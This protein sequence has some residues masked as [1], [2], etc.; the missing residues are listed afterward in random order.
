MRKPAILRRPL[1]QKIS[2]SASTPAPVLGWNARDPVAAMKT[3]FAITLDNFFPT[4]SD[5]MLRKGYEQHVTGINDHTQSLMPY[6][7]ALGTMQLFAAAGDAFYDV[8]TAG[9]VGAAVQSGLTNAKWQHINFATTAGA[10]LLAANGQ[11]N[12]RRWDGSTWLT[13]TGVSTGAIT[14]VDTADIIHLAAHKNRV[15][16]VENQTLNAWHLGT[17]AIAGAATKF[18]LNGVAKK[19]GYLVAIDTWTIDAGEGMDDHWVAVTSEGEVIVY[20]GTDPTDATKWFLVG[21]FN[22]GKPIGRRCFIKWA[23]DL[24]VICED[25]VLPLSQALITDKLKRVAFSDNIRKAMIDA[26]RLYDTNFGWQ[27]SHYAHGDMLIVNV[28]TTPGGTEQHQYVMNTDGGRWCRFKGVQ[29]NCWAILDGEPYFGAD[30]YVG[31]FWG[32]FDDND[33]NING[34]MKQAFN[35]FNSRGVLK[36]FVDVRPTFAAD[37]TPSILAALNIDYS[38]NE[39]TGTLNFTPTSYGVWDSALWDAG[40]WGG[41][42]SQFAEWQGVGGTGFCAAL[43]MKLAAKGIEIRHQATDFLY[44][45]GSGVIG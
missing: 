43:R 35:Y 30:T 38:D 23:G 40:T 12:M 14:G 41:G 8:T 5:V 42:L 34:D 15:W 1:K 7:N 25:G 24:L 16:M 13:I 28:P 31:K 20:K 45:Q 3:E 22:I 6:N 4:P 44:E 19:G 2:R 26:T 18:P 33:T 29:A 10:F 17:D 36:H 11:D 9:A 37:G 21:V 39:P 32:V 27:L